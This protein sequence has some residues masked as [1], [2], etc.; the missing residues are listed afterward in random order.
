MKMLLK[1][2]SSYGAAFTFAMWRFFTGLII[3]VRLFFY[4]REP[5]PRAVNVHEKEIL[6]KWL[7][8]RMSDD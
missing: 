7:G 1:I 2:C 6:E 4:C 8:L 5:S 3:L